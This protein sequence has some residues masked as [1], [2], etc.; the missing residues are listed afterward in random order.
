MYTLTTDFNGSTEPV[1]FTTSL[2]GVKHF[3][4]NT[5]AGKVEITQAGDMVGIYY[6]GSDTGVPFVTLSSSDSPEELKTSFRG[7]PGFIKIDYI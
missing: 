1:S 5:T 3:L 6:D 2:T 7:W 4:L